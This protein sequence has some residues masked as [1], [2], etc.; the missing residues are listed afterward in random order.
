MADR[1]MENIGMTFCRPSQP[2]P[3]QPG[4]NLRRERLVVILSM[5]DRDMENVGM[6]FCRSR[7]P[8]SMQLP[9]DPRRKRPILSVIDLGRCGV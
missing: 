9:S 8:L 6:T 4:R 1:D 7:H 3:V 2:V 5:A